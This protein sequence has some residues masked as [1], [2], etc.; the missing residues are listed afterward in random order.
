MKHVKA[1][2]V[3]VGT[4]VSGLFAALHL[5]KDKKILMI[6]KDELENSDSFLAQGGICVERN[7]ED[8]DSFMEDTLKAGHYENRRESV[9]IMIRSS[10]EVINELIDCGVEFHKKE[11]GELAY[12]REGA[13]SKSRILYHQDVTGKEITSKLLACVQKLSNVELLTQTTMIDILEEK[14]QCYG[15]VARSADKTLFAVTARAVVWACGGIGGLYEHSTN[16]P[17]LTGDALA[18]ALKHGIELEH[19]DYVQIHPTTLYSPKPGRRFLISESVRGE[20]AKLYRKWLGYGNCVK[21]CPFDAIHIING[22]AKVDQEKCK[23]CGKCVAECPK[24]LIEIIPYGQHQV[25]CSSKE[26]GKEVMGACKVG[27]IGCKKCEKECP[28]GAITV[29]DN[30][31]HIDK[32]KCTNCGKCKEVCPRKVIA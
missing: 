5:P 1:D 10:R 22:I 27:C 6:T 21:V 24:H 9:D 4:G 11:N 17:H 30:V 7:E 29:T 16:F 15:I 3:I 19:P 26:K 25:G 18:I 32:E 28:A 12:T 13:H 14:N 31:A 23:S 8:Y 2:V 20:G